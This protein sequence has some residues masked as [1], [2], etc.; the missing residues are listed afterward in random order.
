MVASTAREP[1]SILVDLEG[2][3]LSAGGE[4]LL[5][6]AIAGA[7]PGDRVTVAGGSATLAIELAAFARSHGHRLLD[8]D[9]L[10]LEIGRA[11]FEHRRSHERAGGA[12]PKQEGAVA[13]R[14]SPRWGLSARG[15]DVDL[16]SPAFDF[17]LSDKAVV[18]SDDASRLYA[19]AVA[20]QWDPER[21][22]DWR[23]A[24]RPTDELERAIVQVM[25]YLIE[26]ET[27]ALLVPARFLSR[28]H[29]HFREVMQLLAIQAADEARHVEVFTRRALL[30]GGSLGTSSAGGQASLKTL[31][32]E[33]DYALAMFLLSVLGEGSFLSLLWFLHEHGP[34]VATKQI[35]KLAAQDEARHVAFGLS[36]LA[37]HVALDPA[38]KTRLA[39]A[40]ERRHGA[41]AGTSGI[42]GDVHDALVVLAAGSLAPSAIG[43]GFEA[44]RALERDMEQG[45]TG[46]LLR[47]GFDPGEAERLSALHTKNFM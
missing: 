39:D 46:R 6:R 29:P 1:G 19:Q 38:L 20:A 5:R 40:V 31:L 9:R 45:R 13:E 16:A 14:P 10:C 25:S 32:D 37:R 44:V 12:D 28:L 22:I 4:V 17:P 11:P 24:V 34:D 18:W 27:A 30:F 33:P 3:P 43:R 23:G 35:V 42:N 15:A 26:N 8:G 36:H 47:L 41:L 21:A 7:A 2:L